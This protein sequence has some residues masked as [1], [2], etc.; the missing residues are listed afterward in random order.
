MNSIKE[1]GNTAKGLARNSLGII[2]LFIALIYGFAAL[3]LGKASHLEPTE[4]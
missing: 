2:A 3:V 1:F 4:R